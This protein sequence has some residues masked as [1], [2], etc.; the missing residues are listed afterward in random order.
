MS[1][2]TKTAAAFAQSWNRI[3]SVYSREQF[4][5]W[6]SP[7]TP[8][9]LRD[10]T[11]LELGFGNGSLLVHVAQC[12]PSRL[13]GIDLG[14]T[15]DQTRRNLAGAGV[16]VELHHG[17]LTRAELGEFDVVY[18]IGV[19][20]HLDSP[21]AGFAAVLRHTKPGGRF[22]CWVY[23][24][25]GNAIIRWLV[26]PL[27]RIASRLPWWITKYVLATPLVTPYFLYAKLLRALG[28]RRGSFL[29]LFE[30]TRWIGGER[31]AFFRH[32]AFDQLVT[33]R[34]HYIRRA[35]VE[36]WLDWPEIESAYIVHRN[37]NSW[38]F[39]GR[40]GKRN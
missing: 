40:L 37:G 38:K 9:D 23:A 25:E 12:A 22:H 1:A 32:V 35:T 11:V 16:P 21:D 28:V 30:Y 4:L 17:D 18:C 13:A 7:L 20:H 31:F 14:D 27:R 6:F 24:H 33:P 19:L 39:G 10:R 29:P 26:D 5:E 36:R 34:T 15:I 2:D 3:G 8:H